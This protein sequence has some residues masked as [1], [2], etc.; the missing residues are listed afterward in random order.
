M[1]FFKPSVFLQEKIIKNLLRIILVI[2]VFLVIEYFA[3][4][5]TAQDVQAG[6]W[7][8]KDVIIA[9]GIFFSGYLFALAWN[10]FRHKIDFFLDNAIRHLKN[11]VKGYLGEKSAFDSLNDILGKEYKIYP[12]FRIPETGFDNDFIIIGPKGIL[13]VEVKNIS[14]EY[15]FIKE[16]TFKHDL[17]YGNEC[18]CKLSEYKSPSREILRHCAALENWLVRQ[19]FK[20]LKPKG[21]VLLAG[22]NSWVNKIEQPSGYYV[23]KSLEEVSETLEKTKIDLRFDVDL[24]RQLNSLFDK[25][26]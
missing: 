2:T 17:H 10:F 26:S 8:N 7:F 6:L 5:K 4:M 12:N 16:D 1:K 25:F 11:A 20:N 23:I 21:L 9:A 3:V 14:G 18:L 24:L 22:D 15:D 13:S 19:G